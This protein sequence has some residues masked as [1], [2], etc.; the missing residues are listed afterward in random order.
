MKNVSSTLRP[1][2]LCPSQGNKHGDSSI[3]D[4][5]VSWL[6]LLNG[7]CFYFLIA[8]KYKPTIARDLREV[9]SVILKNP[10][11]MTCL[12]QV[13][14]KRNS[15]TQIGKHF[16]IACECLLSRRKKLNLLFFTS[17]GL[18]NVMFSYQ[19]SGDMQLLWAAISHQQLCMF[20]RTAT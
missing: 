9:T 12:S 14:K 3:T 15:F 4:I 11:L 16:F 6:H 5:P 7:N 20:K 13:W 8:W 17:A 1:P 18:Q 10:N 19:T 2:F